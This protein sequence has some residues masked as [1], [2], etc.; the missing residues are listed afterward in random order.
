MHVLVLCF[1]SNKLLYIIYNTNKLNA[2]HASAFKYSYVLARQ[3]SKPSNF[4]KKQPIV[5]LIPE[6][7]QQVYL[8][9]L[10]S[11]NIFMVFNI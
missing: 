3:S 9:S 2:S 4:W 8:S 10:H 6:Q 7:K 1:A 5:Y 11:T